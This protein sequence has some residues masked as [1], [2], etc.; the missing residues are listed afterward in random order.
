MERIHLV[1]ELQMG[2]LVEVVLMVLLILANY[3]L[4]QP[5]VAVVL[6]ALIQ[7][8]IVGAELVVPVLGLSTFPQLQLMFQARFQPTVATGT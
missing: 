5:E 2:V 3:F 4:V 7:A 8:N 6:Q 1:T